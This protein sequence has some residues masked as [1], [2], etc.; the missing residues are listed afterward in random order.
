MTRTLTASLVLVAGI[1]AAG[2]QAAP[3]PLGPEGVYLPTVIAIY[4]RHA[5]GTV[6]YPITI[7]EAHQAVR[8][9]NEILQQADYRLIG[10]R[11]ISF[12]NSVLGD[13]GDADS[14][15]RITDAEWPSVLAAG[16]KIIADTNNKRGLTIAFVFEPEAGKTTP[17]WSVHNRR[18]IVVKKRD[19]IR[20][21]GETIAHEVGHFL[22]LAKV[23]LLNPGAFP[24]LGSD[25]DGHVRA[26][27]CH[28]GG[29]SAGKPCFF[30]EDCPDT[31]HAPPGPNGTCDPLNDAF[32]QG[33][34]MCPSGGDGVVFRSGTAL[35][36]PQIA[37]MVDSRY[38]KGKCA[39]QFR[40]DIPALLDPE[41]WG[42]AYDEVGGAAA[43]A[44]GNPLLDL[45]EVNV[46]TLQTIDTVEAEIA[47]AA[48]LPDGPLQATYTLGFDADAA[49]AT[50][51][52]YAG[53]AGIDRV[54]VVHLS[55]DGAAPLLT[56]EIVDPVLG[57]TIPLP[58]TPTIAVDRKVFDTTDPGVPFGARMTVSLP[59]ALLGLSADAVPVVA[60]AGD[61]VT[62]A[63]TLDLVFNVDQYT[64]D[65]QLTTSGDG[66][67]TPGGAYPFAIAGLKPNA[68]FTVNLDDEVVLQGTLDGSGAFSGAFTF[69][70]TLSD[71]ERHFLT[72]QDDTGEFGYSITCPRL[73]P[74][75]PRKTVIRGPLVIDA[76]TSKRFSGTTILEAD[77]IVVA[78]DGTLAG[79][80]STLRSL[81]LV[82]LTG[83]VEVHGH[84]DLGA[85]DDI[86]IVSKTGAVR[87]GG[88]V[89][90]AAADRVRIDA[91]GGD[92]VVAPDAVDDT[93]FT[94]QGGNRVDLTARGADGSVRT[95]RAR[96]AG[97]AV[98]LDAR[99]NVSVVRTK[100]ISLDDRTLL[101]TDPA[102]TGRTDTSPGDVT[103]TASGNVAVS[104]GSHVDS[105]RNVWISTLRPGD[106]LCLSK[107]ATLE[108]VTPRGAFGY[109]YVSGVRGDRID[110]TTT[111]I[112]GTLRGTLTPGTCP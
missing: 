105:G 54:A 74:F 71:L 59:K 28:A 82:A 47:V 62:F 80:P 29:P 27:V 37:E 68:P 91:R 39:S 95:E 40:R 60:T 90:I 103:M 63:D 4:A 97:R 31:T 65:P 36:P 34:L 41:G 99:A 110:D 24:P 69:P 86:T 102:K 70:S 25:Q 87:L 9:A 96:I 48:A 42:I 2:A 66:V 11:D 33:N 93:R 26:G 81:T 76:R 21:T 10:I 52:A 78:A 83:D 32:H 89:R 67:P 108:A 56:G 75:P 5:G 50:G 43:L 3:A 15:S 12:P 30:N 14:D 98:A 49:S 57:T 51:V 92:V 107:G 84:L 44:V 104:G 8:A 18:A 106:G 16:E 64:H 61:G 55:G 46:V 73:Q 100:G 13:G 19:T 53:R 85:S 88:D 23:M 112:I 45:D 17:G 20:Q 22:T 72:V 1:L 79:E 35:L 7:D 58:E 38:K 111:T 77:S 101:T 109:V 6:T 94:V